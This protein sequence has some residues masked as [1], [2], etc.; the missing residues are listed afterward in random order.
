LLRVN[1]QLTEES[2][3]QQVEGPEQDLAEGKLSP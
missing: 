2:G 1:E 3:A